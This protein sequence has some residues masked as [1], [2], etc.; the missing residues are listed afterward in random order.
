MWLDASLTAPRPPRDR[1]EG[2]LW[3]VHSGGF[4]QVE[5]RRMGPGLMPDTLH[6]F[7]WEAALTWLSGFLLLIVVYYL[8]GGVYLLDPAVSGI[9]VGAAIAIGL[10]TLIVGW[11][12]YDLLW[13]SPLARGDGRAA[14]V[15]S[16]TLLLGVIWGLCHLLSG[17]AAYLHVG[18][19]LGT[20]MVANVW[21]RV[22]PAQRRMIAATRAGREP[23]HTLGL[24]AKHR[25]TH[26]SYV[27]FPVIAIMLSIH[28]PR[29]YGHELNWLVLVLLFVVGMGVRHFMIGLERHRPAGWALAPA[30]VAVAAL[31]YLT[32]PAWR[33][34]APATAA[35]AGA[36][37]SFAAVRRI[38]EVRCV[39]CHSSTPTDDVFRS[40][41]NAVAFDTAES[42]R[43]RAETIKLRTV[44][45]KTMPLGNKTGMTDREREVMGRWVDE[46]ARVDSR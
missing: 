30:V 11:L 15:V 42:I 38:V 17:R 33:G 44:L 21:M 35:G 18:A 9:G 5:K 1:V 29:T 10:G 13:L 34:T 45:Q 3:M 39:S 26:N 32:S 22:L 25:S 37:T 16:C 46:G 41:P 2:E 6:W 8:T 43:A 12:V 20:I 31:V 27:T 28:Y 23:D 40:A 19:L 36:P 4:Y 24:Q 14:T 7:R